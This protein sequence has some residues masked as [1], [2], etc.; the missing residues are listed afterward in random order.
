VPFFVLVRK[1]EE[2]AAALR[3]ERDT[4]LEEVAR[5]QVD[6]TNLDEQL[7]TAKSQLQVKTATIDKLVRE[8]AS[9]EAELVKAREVTRKNEANYELLQA[10]CV[11]LTRE[12][13]GNTQK[14]EEVRPPHSELVHGCCTFSSTAQP[15]LLARALTSPAILTQCNTTYRL[16][17]SRQQEIDRMKMQARGA[18]EDEE[19]DQ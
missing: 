16:H 7:T 3:M 17:S 11:M 15:S 18:Q 13:L 2:A 6:L 12:F 19:A 5:N 4:A 14:L 10:E 1:L 8:H 9:L